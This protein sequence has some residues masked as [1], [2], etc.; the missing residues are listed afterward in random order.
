MHQSI[1]EI[2]E[3]DLVLILTSTDG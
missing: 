2:Y 1:L 3:Q